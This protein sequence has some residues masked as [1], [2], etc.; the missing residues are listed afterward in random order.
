MLKDEP[1]KN[2]VGETSRVLWEATEK[3]I[4]DNMP[5]AEMVTKL[6][7]DVFVFSG[8]KT[9]AELKEASEL[10]LTGDGKIKPWLQ[11]KQDVQILH[12]TYNID[13][14]EAEYQFATGSAEMASKWAGFEADGN[15]YNLQYRTAGDSQV[16][17]SHRALANIT[18]PVNDKFWEKYYPPNGWRCRCTAVQVRDGKYPLDDSA[19]AG[20]KGDKA[21]TQLDKKGNNTLEI[22]RFNPGKQKV[23]FP[24]KHPYRQVTDKVSEIIK[25]LAA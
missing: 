3:G 22:F 16:R 4:R 2:L 19:E 13:Y 24:P 25:G 1:L 9:H 5:A 21:T 6:R 10:L 8:F 14:L 17:E 20:K 11:F 18:L 7:Q 23:I 12:K 15:R